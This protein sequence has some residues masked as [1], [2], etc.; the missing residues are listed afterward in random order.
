MEIY[1]KRLNYIDAVKGFAMFSIILG[2][3]GESMIT[4]FVFTYHVPIF[5]IISGLFFTPREGLV[6]NRFKQL[7]KPYIT[8]S[9]IILL[10]G[11]LKIFLKLIIGASNFKDILK[12]FASTLLAMIYGSG[13]RNDFISFNINSIGAIWFFLALIWS[14]AFLQLILKYINKNIFQFCIILILFLLG[15]ITSKSTWFPFS[16]QSGMC[17]VIFLYIGYLVK[18][19]INNKNKLFEYKKSIFIISL[20]A[21]IIAIYFSYLN[22]NMSIVRCYFPNPI[23]NL[24]GACG[25]SYT[26]I[27]IFMKLEKYKL[28]YNS[29]LYRLIC[30]IGKNSLIFMCIHLIELTFIP[31]QIIYL[32]PIP[33]SISL[34]LIIFSKIVFNTVCVYIINRIKF[35]KNFFV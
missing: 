4:R 31:W 8:T 11:E 6:K 3:L 14:I 19:N 32:L 26:I 24:I 30:Y 2:H 27:I 20:V 22:N 34:I 1:K 23:I 7:I 13:S 18:M 17:A 9:I 28:V 35:L 16:L 21:W 25:A 10:F 5:F 15:Y 12:Y 29:K 33:A